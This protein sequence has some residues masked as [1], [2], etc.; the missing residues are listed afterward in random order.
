MRGRREHQVGR[1]MEHYGVVTPLGA[2]GWPSSVARAPKFTLPLRASQPGEKLFEFLVGHDRSICSSCAITATQSGLHLLQP[3][4]PTGLKKFPVRAGHARC[5][6]P[7]TP[8]SLPSSRLRLSG[9]RLRAYSLGQALISCLPVPLL[10]G[11]VRDFSSLV[12]YSTSD[13]LTSLRYVRRA[14]S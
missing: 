6:R 4:A 5:S 9:L 8:P 10:K 12:A 14:C 1:D 7:L 3:A 11:L 13:S 2:A